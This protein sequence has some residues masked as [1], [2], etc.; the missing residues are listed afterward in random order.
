MF[1]EHFLC[2]SDLCSVTLLSMLSISHLSL[3]HGS[4]VYDQHFPSLV[5]QH[6]SVGFVFPCFL[7]LLVSLEV[8]LILY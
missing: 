3:F 2:E 5:Y 8:R 7:S 6:F 1:L 4:L